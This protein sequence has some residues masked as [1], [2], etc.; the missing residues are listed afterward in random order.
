[1]FFPGYKWFNNHYTTQFGKLHFYLL[2]STTSHLYT[3]QTFILFCSWG[4]L[5]L[6]GKYWASIYQGK[7]IKKHPNKQTRIVT[8]W[9]S[10][11]SVPCPWS[12]THPIEVCPESP[13]QRWWGCLSCT[14][15]SYQRRWTS[16][17]WAYCHRSLRGGWIPSLGIWRWSNKTQFRCMQAWYLVLGKSRNS[18]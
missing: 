2:F 4:F 1:M 5:F 14:Q 16:L 3:F 7:A 9:W 18:S 12:T 6:T 15:Q 10:W 13:R 8:C 11:H 17:P